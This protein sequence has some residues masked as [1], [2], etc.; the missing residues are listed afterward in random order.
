MQLLDAIIAFALT[1]AALATVVTV[2]IEAIIRILRMR[3]K[4]MAQVIRMLDKEIDSGLLGLKNEDRWSVF[5]KII[6]NPSRAILDKKEP[7]SWTHNTDMK[8]RCDYFGIGK[9]DE[10]N[11]WKLFIFYLK[12]IKLIWRMDGFHESVSLEHVLR[13]LSEA[14]PVRKM[15]TSCRKKLK[16]EF[17]RIALKYEAFQS[18]VSA[19]FKHETQY[20]S[21]L[22]G[23]GLAMVSNIDGL[24]IFEAYKI[25]KKLTAAV[26][27]H[28]EG[29]AKHY[30]ETQKAT[31]K[32][33]EAAAKVDSKKEALATATQNLEKANANGDKAD[34]EN[35]RNA[36]K[37][38][39]AELKASQAILAEE[40]ELTKI[41]QTVNRAKKQLLDLAELGVPLGWAY[42]PDCPHGGTVEQWE[43]SSAMCKA[44]PDKDYGRK[45][46]K[47][48]LDT[49]I[50][51]TAHKDF[52]GF[53]LWL[54]RVALT[55]ILIGLG[56]PFWFDV[57]KRL[58]QVRKGVQQ[59]T[60]STEYRLSGSDA[61]GNSKKRKEIIN[62]VLS[63]AA[64]EAVAKGGRKTLFNAG[65][66]N[67]GRIT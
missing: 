34:I 63:D 39:E 50:L 46:P 43:A 45:E 30:D 18:S 1:M 38:A 48:R 15:S 21:I 51:I 25:D 37:T 27:S 64:N 4:N 16:V 12:K 65:E 7:D 2:I 17:N 40:T 24:R 52:G 5:K 3:R 28:Q 67:H 61:N 10:Q 58:S 56:A 47:L 55:G 33:K 44:L 54:L 22:I 23:I 60:A 49:R 20:W 42:Y 19:N 29:F 53:I 66:E 32:I 14:E 35:Q 11:K 8:V 59:A 62:N 36:L 41:R 31:Q 26:I 9:S 57:A 13:C 6:E